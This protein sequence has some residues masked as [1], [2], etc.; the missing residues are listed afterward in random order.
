MHKGNVFANQELMALAAIDAQQIIMNSPIPV[1]SMLCSYI[2]QIGSNSHVLSESR[3]CGC[4]V[5]GSFNN[6]PSC[7]PHQGRCHC[8]DNVEGQRCDV[9]KPGFFDLKPEY[10]TGCLPCFCHGHSSQCESASGWGRYTFE[11]LFSR[12]AERWK[13]IDRAGNEIPI[14][15]NGNLRSITVKVFLDYFH[16]YGDPNFNFN[17]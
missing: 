1:A 6:T 9:C 5:A 10:P 3:S 7:D 14:T 11:T 13:A 2:C 15:H 12:D 8:K 17:F 4:D 16:K